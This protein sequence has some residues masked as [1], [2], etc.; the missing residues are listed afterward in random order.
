M[1]YMSSKDGN[2]HCTHLLIAHSI[3]CWNLYSLHWRTM[4]SGGGS[5]FLFWITCNFPFAS[6][7][8]WNIAKH[9]YYPGHCWLAGWTG[10]RAVCVAEDGLTIRTSGGDWPSVVH[11]PGLWL[12]NGT[13][14]AGWRVCIDW[15]AIDMTGTCDG[16]TVGTCAGTVDTGVRMN[17]TVLTWCGLWKLLFFIYFKP[18]LRSDWEEFKIGNQLVFT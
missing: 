16:T 3:L 11:C 5:A 10:D 15:L 4:S 17:E 2:V 9:E 1:L 14:L 8:T 13:W 12:M 6:I 18:L 7:A